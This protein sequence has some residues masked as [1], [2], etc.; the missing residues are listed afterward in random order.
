MHASF[1]HENVNF[2]LKFTCWKPV[3]GHYLVFKKKKKHIND[4]SQSLFAK[5]QFHN[6]NW[7]VHVNHFIQTWLLYFI[8]RQGFVWRLIH[9]LIQKKVNKLQYMFWVSF[10]D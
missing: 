2:Y 1:I 5:L 4:K 3:K 8:F 7:K 9:F 10:S 6:G